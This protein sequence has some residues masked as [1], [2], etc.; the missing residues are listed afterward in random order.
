MQLAGLSTTRHFDAKV[1]LNHLQKNGIDYRSR[2]PSA[3]KIKIMED[4]GFTATMIRNALADL[5]R[6]YK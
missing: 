6:S 4:T 2:L 1:L 5:R 3:S